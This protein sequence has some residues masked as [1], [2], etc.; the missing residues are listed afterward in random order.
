MILAGSG[1]AP[2]RSRW[3]MISRSGLR[4]DSRSAT[5]TPFQNSSDFTRLMTSAFSRTGLRCIWSARSI[6]QI[7]FQIGYVGRLSKY[8]D[9]GARHQEI[10]RVGIAHSSNVSPLHQGCDD[11]PKHRNGRGRKGFERRRN[12]YRP[13][14]APLFAHRDGV[15]RQRLDVFRDELYHLVEDRDFAHPE[16]HLDEQHALFENQLKQGSFGWVGSAGR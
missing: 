7:D 10:Q 6:E 5:V 12:C 16:R 15:L 8:C 4:T 2:W 13:L 1:M 9:L 11:L 14:L 3:C